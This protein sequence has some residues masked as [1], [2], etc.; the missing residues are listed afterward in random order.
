MPNYDNLL[1]QA[2]AVLEQND[3]GDYTQPAAGLYPHQ[4]LWDSCFTAI[5]LAHLDASGSERARKAFFAGS[6]TMAC[7]LTLFSGPSRNTGQNEISGVAGSVRTL[8]SMWPPP[9]L[10]SRPC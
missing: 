1:A 9:V 4:W 6:G 3:R 8:P 5:G 7:Y 10:R 2:T